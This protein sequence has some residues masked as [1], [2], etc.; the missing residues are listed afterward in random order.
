MESQGKQSTSYNP[1]V[2]RGT[3]SSLREEAEK[4]KKE[5]GSEAKSVIDE[6]KGEFTERLDSFIGALR[7]TSEQLKKEESGESIAGYVEKLTNKI[8]EASAYL[9]EKDVQDLKV[10]GER[11]VRERPALILGGIFITGFVLARVLKNAGK[12]VM[13]EWKQTGGYYG[14]NQ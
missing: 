12:P 4:L 13:R 5:A 14:G 2:E 11:L 7:H 3:G 10:E 8:E 6:K 9:H 1:E